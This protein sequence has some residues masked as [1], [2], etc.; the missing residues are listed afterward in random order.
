M[1]KILFSVLSMFLFTATTFSY[2]SSTRFY[3]F[4]GYTRFHETT[5]LQN[6][7]MLGVGLNKPI[8]ESFRADL[9]CAY[10]PSE[11]KS[12][13][14]SA[15][16]FY[17]SLSG[18]FLLPELCCGTKPFLTAGLS[19]F[20]FNGKIDNGIELGLGLLSLSKK[21]IEHKF[22]VKARHNPADKQSDIIAIFS[23][24]LMPLNGEKE[25]TVLA[26]EKKDEIPKELRMIIEEEKKQ[27]AIV[28]TPTV[29]IIEKPIKT[30]PV[31]KE[32][33]P[34]PKKAPKIIFD[35]DKKIVIDRFFY[36]SAFIGNP[37]NNYIQKAA[38]TL[39]ENPNLKVSIVGYANSHEKNPDEISLQRAINVQ[40]DLIKKYNISNNKIK[41]KSGGHTKATNNN[42]LNRRVEL[43][44]YSEK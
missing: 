39:K 9:S 42:Y 13:G 41:T 37:G 33:K 21:K 17:S 25:N 24:G 32:S 19:I 23:L 1:R 7:I 3:P 40:N 14:Q 29:T 34:K 4:L 26:P 35:N 16:V 2:D 44:F 28:T 36:N 15:A 6:S 10:L 18:E 30:K 8:T 31:K 12:S 11:Y 20:A 5:D 38:K 22:T 27:K 43:D